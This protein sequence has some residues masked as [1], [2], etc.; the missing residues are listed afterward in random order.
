MNQP[1]PASKSFLLLAIAALVA[2]LLLG[3][4]PS[5]STAPQRPL[6]GPAGTFAPAVNATGPGAFVGAPMAYDPKD[7]YTVL[8]VGS[9]STGTYNQTWKY[10]A[11]T[12]TMLHPGLSPSPRSGSAVA[13][14]PKDHYVVVFGGVNGSTFFNDTWVFAGGFWHHLRPPVSPSARSGARL[15]YDAA[16]GYLVMFGGG[17][18]TG[19]TLLNDTWKFLHGHWTQLN[20]ANSPPARR[21]AGM[22]YDVADGYVLL[23]GGLGSSDLNDTWKFHHGSWTQLT[24]RVSPVVRVAPG[25][26]Y[27]AAAKR[28]ILFG[29]R[30]DN[31]ATVLNDTWAFHAGNWTQLHPVTV[32]PPRFYPSFTF[33]MADHAVLMF[34]GAV[35]PQG[36]PWSVTEVGDTHTYTARN[37]T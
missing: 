6:A 12:W 13:Y 4:F 19:G 21:A 1:T 24:P 31:T 14:D 10:L 34:G 35:Y 26:T 5:G 16:D 22:A 28:V 2:V 9:N 8:Y 32:P 7:G 36:S 17:A 37:W 25:M 3:A 11:G 23:F 30:D 27:D 33:D 15:V 20:P 18:P 29:G